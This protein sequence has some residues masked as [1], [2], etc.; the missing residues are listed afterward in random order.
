MGIILGIDVGGSTTKIVGITPESELL[1]VLQV[2][3]TDQITSMYGAIGH[4][5]QKFNILLKQI[6]RIVLTGVGAS[7]FN[8]NIYG[9]QTVKVDEFIAIGLGGLY[10]SELEEAFI[11]SMG[12]GTAYIRASK[13]GITH[14]GG[15]GV[16]GGTLLGLSSIILGKNDTEAVI[17]LAN[18]GST[19]NVDLLV[20][21]IINE[22]IPSLPE[23]LT[24]AN[25]GNVKST[26][27]EDDYAVGI[28]NM[29]IQTI[30]MLAAFASKN[31]EI[32]TFVM[33][34][35]LT[36]LP[37]TKEIFDAIGNM[38]GIKFTI[39]RNAIFA[40]AIGATLSC[41]KE[42]ARDS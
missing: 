28:I 2:K 9:I 37:Q 40:T 38:H 10:L 18:S 22:I 11:V 4:F 26:A 5:N 31:D 21:D 17:S 32:K 41:I 7:F 20:R 24:A 15:S 19:E 25:F 30:G 35:A 36:A 34:G 29:I 1:G 39:P 8:E 13:T 33:T 23:N 3:A 16:G 42:A 14:I 12:T 6:D 27:A